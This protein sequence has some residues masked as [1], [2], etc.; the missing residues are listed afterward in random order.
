MRRNDFGVQK[1]RD[2]QG[3]AGSHR[4]VA[5]SRRDGARTIAGLVLVELGFARLSQRSLLRTLLVALARVNI[6]EGL[7]AAGT[8]P[9]AGEI[10]RIKVGTVLSGVLRR[11][12][13]R[14]ATVIS[15]KAAQGRSGSR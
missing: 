12:G 15:K 10:V 1:P 7:K 2:A 5:E 4:I 14:L 8:I 11:N 3:I 6:A 9:V 13:Y